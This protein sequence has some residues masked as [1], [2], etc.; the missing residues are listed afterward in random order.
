MD[1]IEAFIYYEV[2]MQ[3]NA[4]LVEEMGVKGKSNLVVFYPKT[5]EYDCQLTFE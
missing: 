3:S 4:E 5:N 2:D 1:Y